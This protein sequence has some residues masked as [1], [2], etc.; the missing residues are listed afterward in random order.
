VST[1]TVAAAFSAGCGAR[2]ADTTISFNTAGAGAAASSA[3]GR[4]KAKKAKARRCKRRK[5][6]SVW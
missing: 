6:V 4:I 3:A 2:A 1:R 5:E